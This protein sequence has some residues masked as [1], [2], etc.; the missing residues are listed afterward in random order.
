M[1]IIEDK[2]N[3]AVTEAKILG[4]GLDEI[5][6]MLDLLYNEEED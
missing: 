5:K 3:E 6:V 4:I 1:R 2:L